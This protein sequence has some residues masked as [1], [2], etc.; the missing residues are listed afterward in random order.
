M[1][2]YHEH[3]QH[4]TLGQE[5]FHFVLWSGLFSGGLI[6][7]GGSIFF[8]ILLDCVIYSPS[9]SQCIS[10]H[11]FQL[12]FFCF[13]NDNSQYCPTILI[14]FSP[15]VKT[16]LLVPLF[17]QSYWSHVTIISLAFFDKHSN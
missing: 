15:F 13:S 10:Y 17:N 2:H 12:Q 11:V 4:L 5:A 3:E 7:F 8:V 14:P 9:F 16:P 1:G 6:I